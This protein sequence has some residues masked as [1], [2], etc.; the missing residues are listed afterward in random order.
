MKNTSFRFLVLFILLV[1]I[2]FGGFYFYQNS[3]SQ[4]FS[5]PLPVYSFME[6]P[7]QFVGNHYHLDASIQ[8]ILSSQDKLGRIVLVSS[9]P[10]GSSLPLFL[11]AD[12]PGNVEFQQRFRFKVSVEDG[13]LLYVHSLSKN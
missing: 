5:E 2:G 4:G 7:L 11:P 6:R 10:E 9:E 12:L 1:L 13:G 8:N 3:E